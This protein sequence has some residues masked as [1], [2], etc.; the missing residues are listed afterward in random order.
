MAHNRYQTAGGEDSVLAAEVALLRQGGHDVVLHETDND[1]IKGFA[2]RLG[3]AFSATY[4]KQA[5]V[6]MARVLTEHQPD[7]VH[8]HNFFPRFS[9]SIY[10]ACAEAGTAVVQ[11]MHNYRTI[12]P[13]ALL[14]RDGEICE[15]CVKGSPYQS[16]KYGCYRESKLGTLA[17]ARMVATHR[18]RGTWST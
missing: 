17:V 12:C 2:A 10:D 4:S 18:R 11:T 8:V 14:M 13:G 6:D 16:V 15:L 9:P 1:G 3:A 5:K 7:V